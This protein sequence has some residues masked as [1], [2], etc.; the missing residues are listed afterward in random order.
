MKSSK[1]L[2]YEWFVLLVVIALL[3]AC[4]PIQPGTGSAAEAP[5]VA[6][7][8]IRIGYSTWVG[9]GAFFVALEKGL[10]DEAGVTVE[11]VKVEDPKL[12]F[13]ALAAGELEGV[14]T[15]LDTMTL[16]VKPDFQLAT[17]IALDDSKGGDGIVAKQEIATVA[18]LKGR[19]VAFNS[20]SVSD[21]YLNYVLQEAGLSVDDVEAVNMQQD[22]AGAAFVAG[23]VDAAVTW[24]PWLSRAKEAPAG[25]VLVDSS[26]NPGL[27][28]DIL[29]F[30]KDVIAA[31]QADI[32]KVVDA[33]WQAIE[34]VKSNPDESI[35]IMARSVGGW[36]EDPQAFADTL[37]GV[38]LYDQAMNQAFFADPDAPGFYTAQFAIDLWT[39]QGRIADPLTAADII[40]NSFLGE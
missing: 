34:Y 33:Y 3:A 18:D 30:R 39:A 35:E 9:Y 31:R 17:V 19:K 21:F 20:G 2:R 25:K 11:M 6:G 5:A 1:R 13:A 12:R 26:A 8:P 23:Q 27:I 36:L 28:V 37:T 32:Q 4:A 15:T 10:F 22:D 16:Y 7:E 14:V 29:L 38:Q 24:E 40:D